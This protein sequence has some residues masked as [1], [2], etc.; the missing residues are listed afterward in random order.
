MN[1]GES[2][3][4]L[5][6]KHPAADVVSSGCEIVRGCCGSFEVREMEDLFYGREE[7]DAREVKV[8]D[9]GV[10]HAGGGADYAVCV[11]VEDI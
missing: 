1:H 7:D 3:F 8:H 10:F 2:G 5:I 6:F 11:P 4:V 9:G